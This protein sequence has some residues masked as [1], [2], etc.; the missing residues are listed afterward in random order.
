[1][2]KAKI[3]YKNHHKIDGIF[4]KQ[5]CLDPDPEKIMDPDPKPWYVLYVR[6]TKKTGQ[7]SY[8]KGLRKAKKKIY[9]F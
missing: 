5:R 4:S 7:E 3:L 9:I 2:K 6:D 8:L 1:M